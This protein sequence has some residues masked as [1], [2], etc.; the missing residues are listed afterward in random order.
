MNIPKEAIEKAINGGWIATARKENNNADYICEHLLKNDDVFWRCYVTDPSFWQSL[1]KALGWTEYGEYE[2]DRK[3]DYELGLTGYY[4]DEWAL[5]AHRFYDLILT[6][7]DTE[8]FWQ[9]LLK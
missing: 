2:I 5:E 8:K 9:E 1:G 4:G 3:S 7:G 6:G